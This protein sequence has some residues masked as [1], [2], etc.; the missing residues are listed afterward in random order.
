MKFRRDQENQKQQELYANQL[1]IFVRSVY[2]ALNINAQN[3][4]IF[5]CIYIIFLTKL[6]VY[7]AFSQK[8][9]NMFL[10]VLFLRKTI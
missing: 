7:Q 2:H 6:K 8:S 3:R 10:Y 9:N 4:N 1:I 5:S